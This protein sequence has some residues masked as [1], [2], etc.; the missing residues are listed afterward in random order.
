MKRIPILALLVT[1]L[2]GCGDRLAPPAAAERPPVHVDSIF[3]VEEEIR[4]FRAAVGRSVDTFDAS[5]PDRE[6]LVERFI[7]ALERADTTALLRLALDRAEF[8]DLYYPHTEY[9]APPYRLSPS[10]VWELMAGNG[11]KGLTRLLRRYAGRPLDYRG[12]VCEADAEHQGP[13][14]LYHECRVVLGTPDGDRSP[15]LFG[16]ILERDG[17]FA[18]VSYANEL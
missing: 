1:A 5:A 2:A 13:N 7:R 8:I 11:G 16:S 3:P 10:V 18:F 9:T 6:A 12:H 17:R 15:R 4:R 14:R